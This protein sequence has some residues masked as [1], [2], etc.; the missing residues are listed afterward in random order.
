MNDFY[1]YARDYNAPVKC[2]SMRLRPLAVGIL[3][4]F[5]ISL[6]GMY[7]YLT[8]DGREKMMSNLQIVRFIAC[9]PFLVSVM[10]SASRMYSRKPCQQ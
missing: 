6:L 2:G 5:G 9:A 3:V 10:R 7:G 4:L 8:R 1:H